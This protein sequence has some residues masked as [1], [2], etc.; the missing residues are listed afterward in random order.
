MCGI[1]KSGRVSN[2]ACWSVDHVARSRRAVFFRI[3]LLHRH[4]R[5]SGIGGRPAGRRL[6]HMGQ[7]GLRPW[8]AGAGEPAG[9]TAW[10][11]ARCAPAFDHP[12]KPLEKVVVLSSAARTQ[13]AP[14]LSAAALAN[15]V[16]VGR[17]PMANML[18]TSRGCPPGVD[19]GGGRGY[20]RCWAD[21]M[22]GLAN[23]R[24]TGLT[25]R[26]GHGG[27]CGGS[28][29]KSGRRRRSPWGLAGA[30]SGLD[31]ASVPERLRGWEAWH[32]AAGAGP[33]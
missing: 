17:S 5:W 33:P 15:V 8:N 12:R 30:F 20:R 31:I 27:R 22:T 25:S 11:A 24:T 19:C 6:G 32:G 10:R 29:V 1:Q 26:R 3:A 14:G 4:L 16:V 13:K 7:C 28:G 18:S 23:A 2:P 21:P 9:P